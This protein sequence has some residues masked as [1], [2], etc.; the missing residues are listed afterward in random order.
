MT[1]TIRRM[2]TASTRNAIGQAGLYRS[3]SDDCGPF[4][5]TAKAAV[6][7]VLFAC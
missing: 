3:G 6:R 7:Q 5:G 4:R 2:S 1:T